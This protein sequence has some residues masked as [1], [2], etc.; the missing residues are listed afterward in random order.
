MGFFDSLV[1]VGKAAVKAAGD[2]ATQKI[3]E[4]W[5]KISK[6]PRDRVLD[7]Y[8]QYNKPE[9]QNSLKRALA[10]AALQDQ[11]L[12]NKDEDAKRQLIRLR[13]KICLEDSFQARS[14][15]RAIDNLQR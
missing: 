2:A 7:Y 10:I 12:F 3:L 14:L 11:M 6:A 4:N 13:E 1:S 8:H 15:I 9:S 5:G